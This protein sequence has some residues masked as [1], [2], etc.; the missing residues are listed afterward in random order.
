MA[1]LRILSRADLRACV[2]M[3]TAIEAV[4]AAFIRL[5]TGQATVPIRAAIPVP[6]NA[7]MLVMPAHVADSGLGVKVVS[8]TPDNP[9]RGLPLI[10]ALVVVLDPVTCAPLAALEGGWLTAWRTGAASGVATSLLA[11]PDARRLTVFGAGAQAGP[12]ILAVCAVRAI[13]RVTI[14]SRTRGRAEA[15]AGRLA[16]QPGVPTDIRVVD[17]PAQAVA[18]ADVVC[19]ATTSPTPVFPGLALPPGAHVNAV[20]AFTAST[21]ETD[22]DLVRRARLVCDER[23]AA[24]EEAGDLVIPWR[25]GRIGGPETWTELGLIAAGRAPSRATG[26]EVTFFKSV[27]NAAQDMAVAAVAVAAAAARGLGAVVEL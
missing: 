2:D 1:Q 27:G 8:V 6:P 16:G 23:H 21:R 15:L 26:D 9:R 11:R 17:D 19:T 3:P 5:S 20:G 13:E 24:Q 12:Q 4:R 14:C 25:A 10:H 7:T 18:D 22:D